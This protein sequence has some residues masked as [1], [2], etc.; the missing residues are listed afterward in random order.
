[1]ALCAS[2][3]QPML[4]DGQPLSVSASAGVAA[5]PAEHMD[6][7]MAAADKAMYR[8]KSTGVA[9]CRYLPRVDGPVQPLHRPAHRLRDQVSD[10]DAAANRDRFTTVES[11]E[12]WSGSSAGRLS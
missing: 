10:A 3:T 12:G 11:N 2:I 9:L 1:H 7:L 8:A 4:A 6:R 5:M